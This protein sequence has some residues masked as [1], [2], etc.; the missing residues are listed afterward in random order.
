MRRP[1]R[2]TMAGLLAALLSA[3]IYRYAGNTQSQRSG[4]N[5]DA[6]PGRFDFYLL[7]LTHEAAWCEDGNE[8]RVQCRALD[9]ASNA[10]RPLVLHGLWPEYRKPGAYPEYCQ[11]GA[12]RVSA[13]LSERLLQVMP[14]AAEG[15]HRHEWRRH[16]SCSGLDPESYFNES[17]RV[18]QR[19]AAS[20]RVALREA[21]GSRVSASALRAAVGRID[22][23]LPE[24][25]V[26]VCKNLRTAKPQHRQRPFLV[27]VRVCIDNNGPEGRPASLLKCASLERRDQG[28]GSA[29]FVDEL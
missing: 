12:F 24:S 27:S 1:R 20:M 2:L 16:G 5:N 18:T 26:F 22:P 3:L 13:V 9:A 7:D 8:N 25:V 28:C 4:A 14:G 23:E 17:I 15:L 11:A 10:D 6:T 21:A 29:F 19:V